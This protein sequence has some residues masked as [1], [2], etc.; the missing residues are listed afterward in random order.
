MKGYKVPV[1]DHHSLGIDVG[2]TKSVLTLMDCMGV[3]LLARNIPSGLLFHNGESPVDTLSA[4]IVDLC[5]QAGLR[6]N[7]LQG[8]AIG[9]P[10]IKDLK[11]ETILSCPN[12]QVLDGL[13][14]G[15]ALMERLGVSVWVDKDTNLL[16]AG[17]MLRGRGKDVMDFACIYV[18]SGLGC[19]LVIRGELYRGAD[20]MAGEVGHTVIEP[21]GKECS[22]GGRGCLEMYCS[23]KALTQQANQILDRGHRQT[24]T[25]GQEEV[26]ISGRRGGAK[27]LIMAA[28]EGHTGAVEA[29]QAAFHYL[30]LAVTNLVN[31]LDL[32]KVILGGG[33]VTNWPGGVAVVAGVAKERARVGIRDY[34]IVEEAAL[35]VD[36]SHI[37]AF[38]YIQAMLS[39][40]RL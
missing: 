20:G 22:C 16:T 18:G 17:E 19:G 37:G 9:I 32:S 3:P 29:I 15:P 11:T 4:A 34:L 23:G 35:G 2:G 8:I 36:E 38:S 10:G 7:E 12:L 6:H 30:G 13:V 26:E 28:K 27:R 39:R 5:K 14:L 1:G 40:G 24:E 25:P 31:T 33:I 21:N